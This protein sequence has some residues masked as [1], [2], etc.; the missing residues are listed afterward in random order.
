MTRRLV[1]FGRVPVP[2]R[3]KTRLARAVGPLAAARLYRLLLE[4]T[5]TQARSAGPPV[6]LALVDTDGLGEVWQPP[7]GLAVVDQGPGGLGD[8]MGRTFGRH[9]AAGA[10]VMV[11]IGSDL[12]G[13]S[14]DLLR[15]AF[16]ALTS[17]PVVLGPS[18]DGGYWLVG[19]RRPGHDLFS[20]IPWSTAEVLAATR[21]RL[22]ELDTPHLELSLRTDLDT[23]A[24]LEEALTDPRVDAT[25]RRR[26]AAELQYPSP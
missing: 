11:L 9:F 14:A 7:P 21:R 19:Q 6:T 24:D 1:V 12:P 23:E 20:G 18:V 22:A 10:E 3:V 25:L 15:D 4:H 26:L 13:L 2:G 5:L 17:A 8:R 16:S